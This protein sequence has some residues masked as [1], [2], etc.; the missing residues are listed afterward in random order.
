MPFLHLE[1][2]SVSLQQNYHFNLLYW[3]LFVAYTWAL[4][5]VDIHSS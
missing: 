1:R 3:V 2:V 5:S 4:S